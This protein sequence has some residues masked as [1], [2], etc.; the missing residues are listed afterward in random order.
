M[1]P[2]LL[3]VPVFDA[4]LLAVWLGVLV[5]LAVFDG[6][7]VMDGVCV[8]DELAVLLAVCDIVFDG[9]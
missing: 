9:V 6:E 4:V 8:R 5:W 2:L 3:G 1:D 7:A